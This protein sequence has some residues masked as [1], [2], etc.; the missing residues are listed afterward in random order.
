MKKYLKQ[1]LLMTLLIIISTTSFA[2]GSRIPFA[3]NL[4][5]WLQYAIYIGGIVTAIGLVGTIVM[6][7][8]GGGQGA[9]L[10]GGGVVV[11]GLIIANLDW[12]ISTL[13]LGGVM[14]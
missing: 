4:D 14:F 7:M 6:L 10:K 2:S 12:V 5:E 1:F 11:G 13:G 3:S 9:A 8:N